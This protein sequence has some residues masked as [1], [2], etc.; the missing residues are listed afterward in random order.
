M[1][2]PTKEDIERM[3]EEFV[4]EWFT[5]IPTDTTCLNCFAIN[6]PYNDSC[7]NCDYEFIHYEK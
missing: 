4:N 5:A 1:S 7:I 2:K 3:A 6:C